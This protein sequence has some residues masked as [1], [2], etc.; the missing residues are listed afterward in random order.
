VTTTLQ[1]R[2]TI[3]VGGDACVSSCAS[4][5]RLVKQLALRCATQSYQ[6]GVDT[7]SPLNI[8][9][10][11]AIGAIFVDLDI[12]E[13]LIAIEFLYAKTSQ[14]LILRIGAEAASV[15]GVGGAFG[16]VLNGETLTLTVDGVAIVVTFVV[17]GDTTAVAIAARINAAA[18]LAGLGFLPASVDTASGQLR[19]TGQL[20]G[21]AGSVVITGG[22][23][24]G[25]LGLTGLSDTG[26]GS[27]VRVYGTLLV[28]FD[29]QAPPARIQ[30]SGTGQLTLL[31][32]GRTV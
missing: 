26:A 10:A 6:S 19:I 29:P 2:G 8:A 5:D 18:I 12:L 9:T 30:V 24:V 13:D 17:P 14:P 1:L 11:G 21:T 7:A 22:T 20:T 27:D 16:T 15:L 3:E 23:A 4:A 25:K 32:A 31:A 28:E